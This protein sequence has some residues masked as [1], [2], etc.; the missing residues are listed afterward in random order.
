[1]NSHNRTKERSPIHNILKSSLHKK[2][3][4][5]LNLDQVLPLNSK[6]NTANVNNHRSPD[7]KVTNPVTTTTTDKLDVKAPVLNNLINNHHGDRNA[8]QRSISP[9]VSFN[10][11]TNSL[12]AIQESAINEQINNKEK[13]NSNNSRKSPVQNKNSLNQPLSIGISNISNIEVTIK[14]PYNVNNINT[15][16]NCNSKREGKIIGSPTNKKE[17]SPFLAVNLNEEKKKQKNSLNSNAN[18]IKTITCDMTKKDFIRKDTNEKITVI[19]E[20][21]LKEKVNNESGQKKDTKKESLNSKTLNNFKTSKTVSLSNKNN[22]ELDDFI[23]S[24]QNITEFA[25]CTINNIADIQEKIKTYCENNKISIKEVRN[26]LSRLI[27]R[28]M[29]V[30]QKTL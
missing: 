28:N 15:N 25:C 12:K 22:D 5:S 23:N 11:T 7:R 1:M 21:N 26:L 24:K 27:T 4:N 19:N 30:V 2:D 16:L 8:A 9:G 18:I 29:S 13:D 3:A 10:N 20:R 17:K 14:K 6:H